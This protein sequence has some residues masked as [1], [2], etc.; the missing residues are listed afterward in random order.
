VITRT[1]RFAEAAR[2][3]LPI[4]LYLPRSPAAQQ[5]RELAKEVLRDAQE[6]G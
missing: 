1:V 3:G 5:Y 2:A 6:E 4:T